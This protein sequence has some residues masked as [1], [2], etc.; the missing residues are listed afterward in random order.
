MRKSSF[1]GWYVIA[2]TAVIIILFWKGRGVNPKPV[3]T[4][5]Q[6]KTVVI[7]HSTTT[8]ID[9]VKIL[10]EII[11]NTKPKIIYR[12]LKPT[13][14]TSEQQPNYVYSPCDSV[15]IQSDT[16]TKEGVKYAIRDTLSGNSIIGRSIR[17]SVPQIIINTKIVD[18]IKTLRVDTVF[19][20]TKQKFGTNAKWFLK[21]VIVGGA[22]GFGTGVF[23]PR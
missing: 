10:K 2:I 13:H 5:K 9:S 7:K 18:S 4:K 8:T 23:V 21:G 1:L 22:I 14:D 19:I 17:F 3:I 6:G 20:T 12:Y 11:A 16:G 15:I